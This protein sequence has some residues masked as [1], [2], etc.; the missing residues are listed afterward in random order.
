MRIKT[1]KHLDDIRRALAELKPEARKR[2]KAEIRSIFGS[3]V[4]G[5]QKGA[6][7]LDVLVEFDEGANLLDL[8]GLSNLIEERLNISVDVVPESALRTE[9]RDRVLKEKLAV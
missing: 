5:E 8:V 4:R 3:Y 6:S 7:D 2:Y 1:K 9:I